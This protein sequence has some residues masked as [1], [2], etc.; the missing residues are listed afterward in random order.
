MA[1][2]KPG[3]PTVKEIREGESEY[4]YISGTGLVLYTRYNNRLYSNSIFNNYINS[5]YI[6][7]C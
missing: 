1:R 5:I 2:I 7:S 4:R 3:V 6:R